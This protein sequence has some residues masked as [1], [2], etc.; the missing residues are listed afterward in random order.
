MEDKRKPSW[1][2][3]QPESEPKRMLATGVAVLGIIALA[4]IIAVLLPNRPSS[5]TSLTREEIRSQ[6]ARPSSY[7][8]LY[9]NI[10]DYIGECIV[11][12]GQVIQVIDRHTFRIAT[13]GE[14]GVYYDDVIY[15]KGYRGDIRL[16][17]DDK[18][19]VYGVVEGL[20]TYTTILGARVTIPA[21]QALYIDLVG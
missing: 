16:L 17:E 13:R 9:R 6:A 15:V 5:P 1:G 12:K 11:F 19:R 4:I 14:L 2:L 3:K 18:V 20:V 10:E 21:V 7:K 8:D